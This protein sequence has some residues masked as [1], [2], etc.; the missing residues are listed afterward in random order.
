MNPHF[1]STRAT[2]LHK[3]LYLAELAQEAVTVMY[4]P[5]RVFEECSPPLRLSLF[6]LLA[7]HRNLFVFT[8][9]IIGLSPASRPINVYKP[10][11]KLEVRT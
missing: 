10:G 8:A 2:D 7:Y 11:P 5:L 4:V 6:S 1:V 3:R 9:F